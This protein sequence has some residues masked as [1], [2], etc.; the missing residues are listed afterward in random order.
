MSPDNEN[1]VH[2]RVRIPASKS[3]TI[4]A[5]F[6]AAFAEGESCLEGPLV[7]QDTLSCRQTIE[8]LVQQSGR[9]EGTGLFM[10]SGP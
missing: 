7:S 4:R 3:H 2:G 6:I 10:D 8:A 5:L 9:M 1:K